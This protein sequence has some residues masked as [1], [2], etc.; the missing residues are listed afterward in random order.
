MKER[1]GGLPVCVEHQPRVLTLSEDERRVL[2]MWAAD[3]AERTLSLF[4]AQ[5]P[6]DTRPRE[7]IDGLRAFA[8]GELGR[9]RPSSPGRV[10]IMRRRSGT[11]SGGSWGTSRQPFAT[12][13]GDYRPRLS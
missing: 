5:A 3:C 2:A 13:C 12:S 10:R 7:A 6:S 8:R 9:V 1:A 4:E 11:R